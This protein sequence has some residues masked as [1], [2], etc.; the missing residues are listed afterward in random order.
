MYQQK[1]VSRLPNCEQLH[2]KLQ[3]NWEIFGPQITF[4]VAGQIDSNDYIAFGLSGSPN[5]TQMIGSDV[6]I[7]YID[8]HFGKTDDYN[9]TEKYP[10]SNWEIKLNP[11]MLIKLWPFWFSVSLVSLVY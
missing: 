3:I 9:L 1:H 8:G 6:A 2:R 4:E 5:R 11:L 7:S 10:V